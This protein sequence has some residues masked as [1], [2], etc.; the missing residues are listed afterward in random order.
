[1]MNIKNEQLPLKME[2]S[3]IAEYQIETFVT[4]H[5]AHPIPIAA[6]EDRTLLSFAQQ[7]LWFLDQLEGVNTAYNVPVALQLTGKLNSSALEHSLHEL[8]HRHDLLRT[9]FP[10]VAGHPQAVIQATDIVSLTIIDL[11]ALTAQERVQKREYLIHEFISRPFNLAEGPLM[12]TTLLQLAPQEHILLITLHQ[13]IFDNTSIKILISECA[14]L[15]QAFCQQKPSPLPPL[16]IQ[17]AD[18]A[19]WQRRQFTKTSLATQLSYWKQQLAGVP[20][21]LTLPTDYPRPP[22]QQFQGTSYQ[23]HFN[24]A[25]TQALNTLSQQHQVTLFTTL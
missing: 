6:Q 13:I 14:E 4:Q 2:H 15:Y 11:Q 21:L 10:S 19:V 3:Q 1:M 5:S 16:P 22:V 9:T 7:R 20:S 12:R 18:F 23:F 8:V 17:Y 25:L 24:P